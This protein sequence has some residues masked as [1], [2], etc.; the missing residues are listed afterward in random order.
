MFIAAYG[1]RSE[2]KEEI[3]HEFWEELNEYLSGFEADESVVLL[4]NLNARVRELELQGVTWKFEVPG[5]NESGKRLIGMCG[6]LGLL[7]GSRC[8][9]KPMI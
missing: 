6:G 1:P 2:I 5:V 4:G 3:R 7:I 9:K 8:F